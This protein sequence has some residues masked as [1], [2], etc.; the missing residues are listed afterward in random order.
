LS[1]GGVYDLSLVLP[2]EDEGVFDLGAVSVVLGV[3]VVPSVDLVLLPGCERGESSYFLY[4]FDR[5]PSV[6]LVSEF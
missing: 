1:L 4:I 3:L 2:E 6:A 5:V